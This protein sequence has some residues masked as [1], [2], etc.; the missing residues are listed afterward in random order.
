MSM[1]RCHKKIRQLILR[2]N[3]QTIKYKCKYVIKFRQSI[4]E[5]NRQPTYSKES[6]L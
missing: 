3:R 4:L 6:T 2:P 1:S 5:L